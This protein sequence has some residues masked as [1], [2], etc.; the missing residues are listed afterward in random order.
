MP[1]PAIVIHGGAGSVDEFVKNNYSAIQGSL[2]RI[3]KA[4]YDM[5]HGGA[6]ALEVVFEV[7][8]QLEDDPLF[9]SGRGSALNEFGRIEMDAA[10]MDGKELLT[11]AV[12]LLQHVKNPSALVREIMK[13]TSHSML[14]AHGALALAK[15]KKLP[16]EP[17]AYFVTQHQVDKFLARRS[18]KSVQEKLREKIHGT[19][20]VAAVDKRGNVAAATSSGGTPNSMAGRIGDSCIIGSGCYANNKTCAVSATG[21]GEYII[22]GVVAHYIS[23]LADMRGMRVDEACRYTVHE[24]HKDIKGD[25][26]VIAVDPEGNI[27]MAFNAER[28]HRAWMTADGTV[29]VMIYPAHG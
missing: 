22:Q 14:G 2:A 7:L 9:N 26:G 1:L 8:A 15:E 16:L 21:D 23:C 4:G 6:P 29:N 19:V 18:N 17:E 25:L 27:G 11:G 12:A 28:M 20:G 10:A 13:D 3:V 24:K 5:L